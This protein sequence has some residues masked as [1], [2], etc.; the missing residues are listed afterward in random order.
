LRADY[1]Y[2]KPDFS[3]QNSGRN[4]NAGR[5]VSAYDQSLSSMN[6]SV[7]VAYAFGHKK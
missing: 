5:E 7:G 1:F 4:N 6:F 2:T 3:I